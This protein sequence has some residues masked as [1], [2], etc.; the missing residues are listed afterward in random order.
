MTKQNKGNWGRRLA[1]MLFNT[2]AA[3]GY[4]L[5]FAI[6]IG[7]ATFIENDFGTSAAQKLVYRAVWFEALLLL[8]AGSLVAN[9]IWYRMIPQ[10]KWAL[11]TLHASMIIILAGA[12][13]TRHFGFEGIMHIREGS[14]S[15]RFLTA[16]S[17][18]TLSVTTGGQE[19]RTEDPLMLSSLGS[20]HWDRKYLIGEKQIQASIKNVIPNP[21]EKAERNPAGKTVLHVV[22]TGMNGREDHFIA[23]GEVKQIGSDVFNFSRDIIAGAHRIEM[24]GDTPYLYPAGML[25]RMVMATQQ[26]DT[27]GPADPAMPIRFLSLHSSGA[28]NFVFRELIP[29]ALIVTGSAS[30]K[31]TAQSAIAVDIELSSGN[32]QKLVRITGSQGMPG[33]PQAVDLEGM[34]ISVSYG[35][36]EREVPFSVALRDFQMDRYPGTNSPASYASEVTVVD[37][38]KG[39]RQDFRIYMNH[40]LDYGGYRFFQSS[41]DNDEQGTYLSVNHDFWGTWIS[42]IGYALLTIGMILSFFHR[43]SRFNYLRERLSAMSGAKTIVV[44]GLMS[45][46]TNG[47]AQTK[48]G[49][50]APAPV[51]MRHAD[52]FARTIVQDMQGRMKPMHT[53]TREVMRKVYGREGYNGMTADQAVLGM[54]IQRGWWLEQPLIKIGDETRRR[55]SIKGKHAAYTDFFSQEGEYRLMTEMARISNVKPAEQTTSDKELI[56]VDERINILNMVFTGQIFRIVPVPGDPNNGWTGT[57]AHQHQDG[58]DHGASVA[59]LFFEKYQ[60]ALSH[61]AHSADYSSADK[62]LQELAAFQRKESSAILPSSRKIS[63]EILLNESAVFMRIALIY[64]VL[65][66]IFLGILFAGV[67]KPNRPF[68]KPQ[69]WLTI[70]TFMAFVLQTAGLGLRWYVSGRAPWSNGYESM[71]YIGWTSALAGLLFTRRSAGGMAATLVLSSTV[72]LIAHLSYLDPEIT[73]LVPVL[74][75]YWLTIHVSLVA[76]SYGFLV[77]GSILG[78][79]NLLL[80]SISTPARESGI[81]RVVTELSHLGEMTLLGGLLMLA[82]GTYLGGVWANESWG[83]YWGWDAKETWALVS[84]LVYAFILHMRLVPGLRGLY[85]FNLATLFGMASVIMTYFGVN[86]YLSGLHSYAAGDPI[87]VPVWVY[88]LSASLAILSMLAW[89]AHR[90]YKF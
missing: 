20:H 19:Y 85:A 23:F 10:R 33:R 71:I 87:P 82:T 2:R 35:S 41:Y 8:F 66:L 32:Q 36:V 5:T 13:V 84:T 79:I 39:L 62:L 1:M 44:I 68:S 55:L 70:I 78:I 61:A 63:A 57:H 17:Y 59:D 31:I 29:G 80:M 88:V 11:L 25:T 9:I 64:L 37:P 18:L 16:E 54:F 22:A 60:E 26:T 27:I 34:I 90:K 12:A 40:I 24:R 76:G 86:Y 67:F 47:H 50:P 21:V 45:I 15:N 46:L 43:K 3:A 51:S 81:R 72:L 14:A 75:S 28:T 56:K 89:R 30:R 4:L 73:P 7:V 83:R 42:Y 69:S 49:Q 74:N 38:S 48:N 65:G 52:L 53:L 77:L 6:S 58:H